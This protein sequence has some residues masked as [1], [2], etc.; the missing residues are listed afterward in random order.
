[1][2]RC[3]GTHPGRRSR[4][5]RDVRK[6]FTAQAVSVRVIWII[7]FPS[8]ASQIKKPSCALSGSPNSMQQCASMSS[9]ASIASDSSPLSM[10][11]QNFMTFP[12]MAPTY[13]HHWR[14]SNV[15][16]GALT[17]TLRA[18]VCNIEMPPPVLMDRQLARL[19]G[20]PLN[21]IRYRKARRQHRPPPHGD[22]KAVL[23]VRCAAQAPDDEPL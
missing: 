23:P 20:I 9:A 17:P 13:T 2:K 5:N 7:A 22:R 11:R 1:M 6:R 16:G 8:D 3:D 19:S 21:L 14:P 18:V 10:N 15:R 12:A 4:I